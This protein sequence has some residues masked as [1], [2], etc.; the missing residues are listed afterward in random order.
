MSSI[1]ILA[2][3]IEASTALVERVGDCAWMAIFHEHRDL[4]AD[5]LWTHRGLEVKSR[6]D[7]ILAIFPDP[8]SAVRCAL[9]IQ[10]G[11]P[12][13][14]RVKIG[15]HAGAVLWDAGDVCGMTVIVATRL[16]TIARGGEILVSEDTRARLERP[17]EF[18]FAGVEDVPLKG[19]RGTSRVWRVVQGGVR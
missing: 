16:T 11:S 7:G 6:G 8:Q 10:D 19:L 13:D 12:S 3:D 4:V 9:A 2:T 18:A 15:V 5:Q 14:V 17:E 1:A